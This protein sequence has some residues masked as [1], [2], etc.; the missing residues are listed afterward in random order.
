M[1]LKN[2]NVTMLSVCKLC[3]AQFWFALGDSY[4]KAKAKVGFRWFELDYHSHVLD[5]INQKLEDA[6][7]AY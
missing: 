6:L 4:S 7:N 1:R 5:C 3:G 2:S